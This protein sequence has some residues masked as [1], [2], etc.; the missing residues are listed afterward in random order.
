MCQVTFMNSDNEPANTSNST[1]TLLI[2]DIPHRPVIETNSKYSYE[3][4]ELIEYAACDV[5]ACRLLKSLFSVIEALWV[6]NSPLI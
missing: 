3:L 5:F 6:T 2:S 1:E 4:L